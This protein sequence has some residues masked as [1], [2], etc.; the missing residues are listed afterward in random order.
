MIDDDPSRRPTSDDADEGAAVVPA[1]ADANPGVPRSAV[2]E[3]ADRELAALDEQ[4][5]AAHAEAYAR[6]HAALQRE[7][8]EIDG[9]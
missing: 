6:I 3:L 9:A 7:L 4:P 8:V 5:I 1:P 2:E